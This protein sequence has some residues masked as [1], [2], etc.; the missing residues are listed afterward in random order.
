M[1]QVY[2]YIT[3]S[4]V[5]AVAEGAVNKATIANFFRKYASE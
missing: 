3:S 2:D 1:S 5:L 4:S